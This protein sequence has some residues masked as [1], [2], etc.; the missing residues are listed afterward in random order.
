MAERFGMADARC[1]TTN[2]P[3]SI[4]N[5][6]IAKQAGVQVTDGHAYRAF[7]IQNADKIIQSMSVP[8]PDCIK[9]RGA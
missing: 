6:S 1:F 9:F 7:L 3:S 5:D 2:L 8:S 4:L